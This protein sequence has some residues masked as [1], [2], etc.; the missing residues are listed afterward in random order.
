[1]FNSGRDFLIEVHNI[2]VFNKYDNSC[3]DGL[4]DNELIANKVASQCNKLFNNNHS[5]TN[6]LINLTN[7]LNKSIKMDNNSL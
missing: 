2:R 1:M 5:D 3:V 6:D 4:K 7:G